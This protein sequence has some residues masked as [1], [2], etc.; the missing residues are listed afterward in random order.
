M[1]PRLQHP[2]PD[3]SAE[4]AAGKLLAQ[5]RVRARALAASVLRDTLTALAHSGHGAATQRAVAGRLGVSHTQ[6]QR[7]CGDGDPAVTL[8]DVLAMGPTVARAV[9]TRCLG[10]IEDGAGPTTRDSLDGV[11]IELGVAIGALHTDLADGAEDH[12]AQHAAAL[13]RIASIALRGS[14]AARRRADGGGR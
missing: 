10:A 2:A 1:S 4:R 9:L 8:G 7:W 3:A 5:A 11:A 12:P 6:V 13:E 14:L